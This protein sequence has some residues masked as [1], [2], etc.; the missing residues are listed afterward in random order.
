LFIQNNNLN[1][2]DMLKYI[3]HFKILLLS[4][5]TL[6]WLISCS[7]GSIDQNEETKIII[8]TGDKSHPATLHEYIKNARLIKVMLDQA[9]NIKG[10]NTEI[11][12]Q[13]WPEDPAIL[14][15]ADL[16]L[17]ISDGRDGPGGE[18]VPFLGEGRI[19]IIQKQIDRGCGMMTFHFST[20]TPDKYSEQILEWVG[21]YF[22]WQND[23][24]ER[25][26]YSDI[27][28]LDVP[29]A[30]PGHEHPISNGVE[31]F[32]I[33]EEYYYDLRFRKEDPRFTPIIEVPQLQNEHPDG[34]IIAWA[35]ERKDGGKGFGTSLGHFYGNWKNEGYRKLLLNSIVWTAGLNVPES[36]VESSF[37]NDKQ[38]TKLLYGADFKG[39]ILTGNNYPGHKWKETTPLIH[40]A[41]EVNNRIH[42]DISYNINDLYQYDL[43]DYDFLVFNYCNWE[44]PD[45]LWEGS[46]KSLMDYVEGGGGLMFIHFANGAFHFS[47]PEAGASDW[48]YYRK[49]CRRIWN[50]DGNSTHDKYGPFIVNVVDSEHYITMAIQDFQVTDELYYNQE[51]EEAVHIILSAQSKDTGKEEP[52]AWVYEINHSNGKNSRVFQ[53]VLGHDTVSLKVPELQK[54]LSDA[55]L[56]I[57]KG[58][59]RWNDL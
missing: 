11:C 14:D 21:G 28:F 33:V 41:L 25:E 54:I 32:R 3:N 13:G 57:S 52:Q 9:T 6:A 30:L 53:T 46:K 18:E 34:K 20:F 27:T 38:V 51:G 29:V 26:W 58:S 24:G 59:D 44:D 5:S 22:D 16:I 4:L 17:T 42:M 55:G 23:V 15:N 47:L 1:I 10:I 12:Y 39:L 8:L 48:P 50:H 56:W 40:K 19:E 31:P 2:T 49:L 37:Y 7:S 45:P 35:I 43:R 36:G